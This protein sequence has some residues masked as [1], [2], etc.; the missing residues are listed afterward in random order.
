MLGALAKLLAVFTKYGSKAVKA[1]KA[2]WSVIKPYG[3]KAIDWIVKNAGKVVNAIG[4]AVTIKDFVE[5]IADMLDK[6]F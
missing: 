4:T 1:I 2:A 3:Q 5:W 6:L